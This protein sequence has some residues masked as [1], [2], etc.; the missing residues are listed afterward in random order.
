MLVDSHCHL[1]GS[2]VPEDGVDPVLERARR[3]GVAGFVAVAT[4]LEEAG[5]VLDLARR[6][7]DVRVALG[8]HPHEAAGWTQGTGD[9]LAALLQDPLVR[10]VGE[11]GLD[12]HY[13][14]SPRPVQ[15]AVFRAHIQLAR[16]A[17]KPIVVHT[18]EAPGETLRILKE[19]GASQVGG[20][21]H[22]FSE[23][24]PFAR[25]ALDLGFHLSFSGIVTFKNAVPIQEVAAWAP[26]DRILVETDSPYLAPAP[27]R[28]KPNEPAHVARVAAQVAALRG[29]DPAALAERTTRNLEALCGWPPCS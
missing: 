28:G 20:I 15:E 21:I 9:A 1:V 27:F 8:V 17:A 6:Q 25:Q 14:F 22:C 24:L 7:P 26:L 10:F 4:V 5:Q 3:A 16:A 13:D 11:T 19:E 23:D 29:M 18:R 12:W 2:H